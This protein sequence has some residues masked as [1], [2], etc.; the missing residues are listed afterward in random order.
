MRCYSFTATDMGNVKDTFTTIQQEGSSLYKE[1][2]SKFIG[3]AFHASS[4][5]EA[6]IRLDEIR[7]EHHQSRHVCYAYI[8]DFNGQ[9]QRANDD[10]EPSHSAGTPILNQ[11]F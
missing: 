3:Y 9:L 10:G 8:L 6:K 11:I 2:G 4:E 7:Q 1:K 5:E